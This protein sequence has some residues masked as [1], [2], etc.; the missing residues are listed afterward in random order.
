MKVNVKPV[1]RT[2]AQKCTGSTIAQN[3]TKSDDSRGL[4][5]VGAKSENLKGVEVAKSY[6]HA[7]SQ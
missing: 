5:K 6:C 7:S 3:G 2:K 4:Q 1:T